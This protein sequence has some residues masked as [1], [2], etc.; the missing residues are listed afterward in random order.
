[1]AKFF[2]FLLIQFTCALV[3]ADTLPEISIRK[4]TAADILLI[5]PEQCSTEN[6]EK[7]STELNATHDCDIYGAYLICLAE[8]KIGLFMLS[9]GSESTVLAGAHI[10]GFKTGK[11]VN[12]SIV[13]DVRHQLQGHFKNIH[14]KIKELVT[15][16]IG[17]KH[18]FPGQV[19]SAQNFE[20]ILGVIDLHNIPG[21]FAC[22]KVGATFVHV[23][24][25][26]CWVL[27]FPG[28][29]NQD[30]NEQERV[31]GQM[32]EQI[33]A[34]SLESFKSNSYL[35]NDRIPEEASAAI[36]KYY[37]PGL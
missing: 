36:A 7:M 13:L 8:S 14:D 23:E 3:S 22:L 6:A 18:K 1:M 26:R 19:E 2:T 32:A 5:A 20:G 9:D 33:I 25:A 24:N 11:Y 21:V 15:P 30:L 37:W 17:Q 16:H 28:K 10:D 12:C 29:A 35:L 31:L 4:M 27:Q 34:E